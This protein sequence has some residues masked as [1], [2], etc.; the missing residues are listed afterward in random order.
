MA[1]A[2][3]GR[4]AR[5][6][7]GFLPSPSDLLQGKVLNTFS[8][9]EWAIEQRSKDTMCLLCHWLRDFRGTS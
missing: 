9:V 3:F 4:S 6:G 2:G 8:A 1:S 7:D 5:F